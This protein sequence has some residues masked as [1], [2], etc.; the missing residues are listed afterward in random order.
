MK[1]ISEEK[2]LNDLSN[3]KVIIVGPAPEPE[4]KDGFGSYIDSFDVVVRV[5]KGWRMSQESPAIF[6]SRTDILYHCLDFDEESGGLIDY[7]FLQSSGCEVIFSCYPNI[8]GP[9]FRDIMLN[10]GVRHH[11]LN[12]FLSQNGGI[13]YSIISSDYYLGVDEEM[14]TRPNSGTISFLHLLRSNL[15][16]L[17]IVGFSFFSKGYVSSYRKSID[18]VTA[19]DE[20][21][22]EFLVLDRL[23]KHG[24]N[25]KM[26]EQIDFCKPILGR[27]PRV[28]MSTLLSK[29]L[30][31]R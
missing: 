15:S 14:N 2:F 21:H 18:G 7:D 1:E 6:G 5:N 20:E 9:N 26:Q 10:S 17:H 25:H 13:D 29:V 30:D 8:S 24:D 28:K 19:L 3:K 27:D 23:K 12:W 22:S 4:Y 31:E 16:F 11:C